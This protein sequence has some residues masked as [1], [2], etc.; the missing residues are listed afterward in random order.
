ME[1]TERDVSACGHFTVNQFAIEGRFDQRMREVNPVF[2][3]YAK[4]HVIPIPSTAANIGGD[5]LQFPGIDVSNIKPG[6]IANAVFENW[7]SQ[8]V[9]CFS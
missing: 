1:R 2:G 9:H 8:L 7:K 4:R 3:L 5:T 6:M